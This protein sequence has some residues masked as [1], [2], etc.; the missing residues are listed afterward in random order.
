MNKEHNKLWTP[1]CALFS[2]PWYLLPPFFYQNLVGGGGEESYEC[3]HTD[4]WL[5]LHSN[6][7]YSITGKRR[8]S[9]KEMNF[10]LQNLGICQPLGKLI[11]ILFLFV[12]CGSR[13]GFLRCQSLVSCFLISAMALLSFVLGKLQ[14]GQEYQWEVTEI[15]PLARVAHLSCIKEHFAHDGSV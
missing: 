5:I 14:N 9:A 1:L 8:L 15:T 10:P 3:I 4:F 11:F 7:T 6:T 2:L 13:V 12:G